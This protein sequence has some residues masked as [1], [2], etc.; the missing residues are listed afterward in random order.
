M[1]L[2]TLLQILNRP[3]LMEESQANVFAGIAEQVLYH[4]ANFQS[5]VPGRNPMDWRKDQKNQNPASYGAFYRVNSA[6]DMT[7]DG[8][9]LV[10]DINGPV[11][12]QDY[13]GA[14]G[15]QSIA[16]AINAAEK[17][18]S[19]SS[20]M[21]NIDSPGGTVDGTHNLA[22]IVS[23]SK[24]MGVAYVDGMM[25]SAAYWIGSGSKEIISSDAN[26][27]H[28]ATIGS[29]GTMVQWL[30]R[31]QQLAK[32]G[33]KVQTVYAS[34]SKRKGQIYRDMQEGNYSRLIEELDALNETFISSINTNRAGKLNLQRDDVFEGD[35]YN[36]LEAKKLGLI[37]KIGTWDYA[38]KRSLQISKSLKA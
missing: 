32:D 2:A 8:E 21:L 9:L 11:M 20:I 13:C 27:G 1:Q 22:R 3:W 30:D 19:I 14:P 33:I 4:G 7:T 31:S 10:I 26:A 18:D 34:K 16:Q 23:A 24:K 17:D 37:D 29:I 28:N 35:V 25:C 38:V 36:A 6:G 12:K 15:M 5:L